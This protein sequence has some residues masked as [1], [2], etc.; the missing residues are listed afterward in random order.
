MCVYV[1]VRVVRVVCIYIY[2]CVC[3]CVCVCV[4][5]QEWQ[6][7][8]PFKIRSRVCPERCVRVVSAAEM[9]VR[10]GLQLY[11]VQRGIYLLDLQL[12]RGDPFTFM[13]L[14][15]RVIAELKVPAAPTPLP[16]GVIAASRA[17]AASPSVRPASTPVAKPANLSLSETAAGAPR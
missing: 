13:N 6:V 10:L 3:V 11:K 17:V 4:C 12:L 7:V 2:I 5:C 15:A 14:C 8:V 1:C 16:A 9:R